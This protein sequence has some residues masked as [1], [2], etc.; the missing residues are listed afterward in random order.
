[1]ADF[2]FVQF[3]QDATFTETVFNGKALWRLVHFGSESEPIAEFKSDYENE[4]F[5][6]F[7]STRFSHYER[8][9]FENW[10]VL[11]PV[12][13]DDIIFPDRVQFQTCS[14]EKVSF[15]L[16]DFVKV[17]FS[18][19]DFGKMRGRLVFYH[20]GI[21][22][23]SYRTF[24]AQD[25]LKSL[26]NSYR[27]LKRNLMD[28]KDW[29]NAGD[30]YKSEMVI[31]RKLLWQQIT[32]GELGKMAHWLVMSFYQ[33]FSGYQQSIGRPLYWLLGLLVVC[34]ILLYV[35]DE[36]DQGG[37]IAV[38]T[39]LEAAFPFAGRINVRDYHPYF[40]TLL[41]FERLMSIVL[42][43]FFGLATRA[44]LRQ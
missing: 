2:S 8:T 19:C 13:F 17:K 28:S 9:L 37:F 38:K 15:Y 31:T 42:L 6:H 18:N 41:L 7:R 40:Y 35:F 44:R 4:I 5:I 33:L 34:P 23:D 36:K 14:M 24:T 10:V 11:N 25:Y 29:T 32:R 43:T 21:N 12:I 3:W 26:S 27:Q 1:M 39:S 30:A 16:C 20:E 22:I